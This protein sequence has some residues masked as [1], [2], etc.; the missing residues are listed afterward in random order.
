MSRAERKRIQRLRP[1]RE[2]IGELIQIDGQN[3]AGLRIVRLSARHLPRR[4]SRASGLLRYRALRMA[5]FAKS[6]SKLPARGLQGQLTLAASYRATFKSAELRI[7]V[8]IRQR[9]KY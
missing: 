1:S 7:F 6:N 8:A 2:H 4:L 9:S 5:G 3:I